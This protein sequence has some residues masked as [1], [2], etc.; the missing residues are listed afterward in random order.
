ME[1]KKRKRKERKKKTKEKKREREKSGGC[2]VSRVST[3]FIVLFRGLKVS[4]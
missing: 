4:M 2:W 3:S 1:R